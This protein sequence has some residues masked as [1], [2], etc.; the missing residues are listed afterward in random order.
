MRMKKLLLTSAILSLSLLSHAGTTAD[1]AIPASSPA[2][3]HIALPISLPVSVAP[4]Q[5]AVAATDEPFGATASR[6]AP[7]QLA[8]VGGARDQPG[9]GTLQD[10][11]LPG[12]RVVPEAL[13]STPVALASLL[14]MICI[15]VRRRKG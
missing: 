2:S 11:D 4:V 1:L 8:A 15:L 6:Q 9:S 3:Q 13:P 7:V 5:M 12:R 14:L 10:A